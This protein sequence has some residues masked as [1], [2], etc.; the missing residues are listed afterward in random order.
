MDED[1]DGNIEVAQSTSHV[2][3]YPSLP[4]NPQLEAPLTLVRQVWSSKEIEDLMT[5]WK[6][7]CGRIIG[8]MEL[9]QI[10]RLIK[11][12]DA[13]IRSKSQHLLKK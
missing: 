3:T 1:G 13:Q 5:I 8:K 12:S 6:P 11:R 7:S 4:S 2:Q 10:K 9:V